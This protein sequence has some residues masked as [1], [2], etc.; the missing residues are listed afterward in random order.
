MWDRKI[1]LFYYLLK[2]LQTVAA[3]PGCIILYMDTDSVIYSHP[4]LIDPLP[5]GPHIGDL[6]DEC[7]GK[8]ILEYGSAGCKNYAIEYEENGEIKHI[9]KIRGFPLD[10]NACESIHYKTFIEKTLNFGI[11]LEPI[12]VSYSNCLRPNLKHGTVYTISQTKKYRPVIS[13]GV[14]VGN[15]VITYGY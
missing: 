7:K 14:V 3:T 2:A 6:T 11:D 1:I 4:E 10:S 13:K 12:V 8:R 5:T 15:D 9:L